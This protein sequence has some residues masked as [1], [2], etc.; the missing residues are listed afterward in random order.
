MDSVDVLSVDMLVTDGSDM[1]WTDDEEDFQEAAEW[2]DDEMTEDQRSNMVIVGGTLPGF[3]EYYSDEEE[4]SE[5]D[6]DFHPRNW[7]TCVHCKCC[8]CS[9]NE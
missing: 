4:L 5:E 6:D 8:S 7:S 2:S 3:M 1:S 9:E